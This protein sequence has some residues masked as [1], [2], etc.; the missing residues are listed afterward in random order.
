MTLISTFL[1]LGFRLIYNEKLPTLKPETISMLGLNLFSQL[2]QLSNISRHQQQMGSVLNINNVTGNSDSTDS[3]NSIKMDQL[4]RIALC[5]QNTD[6]SMKAIQILN[7]AYF[8]QGEEFLKT[9]MRS[10]KAASDDLWQAG[11]SQK[12]TST[13]RVLSTSTN[14]E[15]CLIRIQRALL[16]LKTYLETFRRKYAYHFRRMSIDGQGV[17]T[18]AEL[19]DLRTV[20]PLRILVQTAGFQEKVT[21]D[22][23][24][25]DLIA[26]LRAEIT[27]WWEGKLSQFKALAAE[28]Q[29]HHPLLGSIL[30]EGTL[31]LITQGQEVSHEAD[32]KSL[33]EL[34]F[35][36]FQVVFVSQGAGNPNRGGNRGIHGDTSIAPFPGKD[37][38]P[39]NLLLLPVHFDQ[40]FSLMQRLSDM[41]FN[42]G[43]DRA[44]N[45]EKSRSSLIS[46]QSKAQILSRRVWDILMLLPTSPHLKERLQNIRNEENE[47]FFK[48]LLSPESPQK[49]MYTLYIVDWLGRPARLRRH[50]GLVEQTPSNILPLGENSTPEAVS[51]ELVGPWIQRFIKAGGL[52]HLFSIFLSGALQPSEECG[53]STGQPAGDKSVWWCE[54]KQDC[55]SALL[56]LLVQFGVDPQDYEVLADQMLE[57]SS[58]P[59]KRMRRYNVSNTTRKTSGTSST[60]E[61]IGRLLVPRLSK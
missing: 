2:C 43:N 56:K 38:M 3:A 8:S 32:E 61:H 48:R 34:G 30:N 26:D 35:K 52:R 54:W 51:R 50:S 22:M 19:V 59:R 6:V 5:A 33:L 10:L 57:G 4:W 29:Q 31:R 41:R 46:I 25:T 27:A 36:D 1:I 44:N 49:L 20:G 13:E 28:K 14:V 7:S 47:T 45:G 39:M 12:Y 53:G 21:F 17:S 23:Q 16:L 11:I 60:S 24:A 9:C 15:T 42:V 37:H 55:L 40:L 58:T 18:H